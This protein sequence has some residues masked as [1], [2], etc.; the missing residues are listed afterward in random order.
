MILETCKV[1]AEFLS[2]GAILR[3]EQH[4]NPEDTNQHWGNKRSLLRT[5]WYASDDISWGRVFSGLVNKTLLKSWVEDLP[6]LRNDP[7]ETW[8][9]T[10]FVQLGFE[11]HPIH[12]DFGMLNTRLVSYMMNILLHTHSSKY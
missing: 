11:F 10:E 1:H 8:D 4:C 3:L 9:D 5:A 12:D 6:T 7:C 2:T